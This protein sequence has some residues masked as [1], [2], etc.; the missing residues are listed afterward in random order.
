MTLTL[1][2]L[3]TLVGLAVLSWFAFAKVDFNAN[4][5]DQLPQDKPEVTALREYEQ[6]FAAQNDSLIAVS[7]PDVEQAALA[8]KS[9]LAFLRTKTELFGDISG[10]APWDED[11]AQMGELLAY[12]WLNGPSERLHL[13][14]QRLQGKALTNRLA[15]ALDTLENSMDI[16]AL[17]RAANDPLNLSV[18]DGDDSFELSGATRLQFVSEDGELHIMLVEPA[19]PIDDSKSVR[20]WAEAVNATL[21]E[22]RTATPD[23]AEGTTIELT[24]RTV[25]MHETFLA[26]Q[27]DLGIS[28]A[29]TLA[30]IIMLFGAV[31][32]RLIPLLW[33]LVCLYF[34]FLITLLIGQFFYEK[35]SATS[36][37]F[38][39][40]LLGLAVDYG[41][42]IYQEAKCA[43]KE[44]HTM[45]SVFGKSIGWAAITTACVF[46]A[47]NMSS[48]P[49]ITQL[50][51][52]IAIGITVGALVMIFIYANGLTYLQ[53]CTRPCTPLSTQKRP[54]LTSA[55]FGTWTSWIFLTAISSILIIQKV[56]RLD[57]D[58]TG[59]Q[60][61][62]NQPSVE[63]Y[64]AVMKRL[65]GDLRS[66]TLYAKGETYEDLV[67]QFSASEAVLQAEPDFESF[68]LPTQLLP[69]KTHQ[70]ANVDSLQTL[71][72][73]QEAV[74]A[75]C[76]QE[77]TEE[78]LT[79]SYNV[80]RTWQRFINEPNN[81]ALQEPASLWLMKRLIVD[82]P[83]NK[84]A[85]GFAR[86]KKD[87]F[88]PPPSTVNALNECSVRPI[89]WEFLGPVILRLLKH[90][91]YYVILP[92]SAVLLVML[93]IV[94]RSVKGVCLSLATL[95]VSCLGLLAIMRLTGLDW[96]IVNI[97]AVP[98][99]LGLGLDY[100]IHV[101]LS[102]RRTHGN[103]LKFRYNIGH[104]LLLCGTT[105]AVGFGSLRWA[106]HGGLPQLGEVCAIG[107]LITMFTA[108]FLLPHWWRFLHR[109]E[110]YDRPN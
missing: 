75:A 46:L 30:F 96:N 22:W 16:A 38:A 10:Q 51:T 83:N 2:C 79:L 66:I 37:G 106:K 49:G 65:T 67:Q 60:P 92:T 102:L 88:T 76:Q 9:L 80:F 47:L 28:V 41:F 81:F 6:S 57:S 54:L 63:T 14:T 27:R 97:A 105:T 12:L 35:L 73:L 64:R 82:E 3:L 4:P 98:V 62:K 108:I 107:I 5:L 25:F 69:N 55:T 95:C 93:M 45:R 100:S 23:L 24:G 21:T 7:N 52:M 70:L 39:A 90:E 104:A 72:S 101:I 26:L 40:I 71:L 44:P 78:S 18:L 48:M 58:P 19:E 13:L 50:G 8:A 94:F 77:F 86:M 31:Q 109:K 61:E 17:T 56:P 11:P 91:Q 74:F 1:R 103:V 15:E 68:M 32:R 42:V 20:D 99:L 29:I 89:G 110:L 85:I 34:T 53:R 43:Q 33:L 84:R 36:A 87:H 59:L